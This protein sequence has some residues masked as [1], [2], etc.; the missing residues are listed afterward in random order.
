VL[1]ISPRSAG[2]QQII[3]LPGD[4]FGTTQKILPGGFVAQEGRHL[5][6]DFSAEGLAVQHVNDEGDDI[7]FSTM[8]DA[9]DVSITQRGHAFDS[10]EAQ[11]RLGWTDE[12]REYVEQFMLRQCRVGISDND[13]L[14]RPNP[15]ADFYLYER[16]EPVAPWPTYN[17]TSPGRIPEMAEA[18]G[19]VHEALAYERATHKR[20]KVLGGL[21]EL[22][23]RQQAEQVLTA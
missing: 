8:E 4:R 1:F 14:G 15:K 13:P 7:S 12:E 5:V 6:A 2:F 11:E 3:P 18:T 9:Y 17:K 19:T 20:P 22:V 10:T 21:E 16:P 23:E